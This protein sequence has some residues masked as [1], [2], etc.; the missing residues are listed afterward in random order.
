M[1]HCRLRII[2]MTFSIFWK[3]IFVRNCNHNS[4]LGAVHFMQRW[5]GGADFGRLLAQFGEPIH[6]RCVPVWGWRI[7][8]GGETMR[9]KSVGL[10]LLA[11]FLTNSSALARIMQRFDGYGALGAALV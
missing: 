9:L 6:R 2:R 4:I 8:T 1:R 3:A 7:Q 5:Q 10:C 11:L